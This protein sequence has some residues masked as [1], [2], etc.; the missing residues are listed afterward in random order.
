MS[1]TNFRELAAHCGHKLEVALYGNPP[2]NAAIECLTCYEVLV[3]Y[4]DD[5][6]DNGKNKPDYKDT[7]IYSLC[8]EDVFSVLSELG[9]NK[10]GQVKI[11]EIV[12]EVK[13]NLETDWHD[14]ISHIVNN[15]LESKEAEEGGNKDVPY[16]K[17]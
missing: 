14:Y 7:I 10:L 13:A 5:E 1:A 4:E 3:D 8:A 12:D 17:C 6:D 2:V 9:L 11:R 15:Y 16:S